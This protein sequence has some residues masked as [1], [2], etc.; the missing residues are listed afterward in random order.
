MKFFQQLAEW[1]RYGA[2][3]PEDLVERELFFLN[4][5]IRN[6]ALAI[7]RMEDEIGAP[8]CCY[9]CAGG[10]PYRDLQDKLERQEQQRKKLNKTLLKRRQKREKDDAEPV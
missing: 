5:N 4:R 9:W 8:T 3:L 7:Q 6:S 2:A 1:F 10:G